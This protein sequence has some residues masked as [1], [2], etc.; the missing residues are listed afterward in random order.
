MDKCR[1]GYAVFCMEHKVTDSPFY[2]KLWQ[3]AWNARQPEVK[4]LDLGEVPRYEAEVVRGVD[5]QEV[6]FYGQKNGDWVEYSDLTDKLLP[7]VI[8][9]SREQMEDA[10]RHFIGP[11]RSIDIEYY[12][13]SLT[14]AA[15]PQTQWVPT[16]H[17]DGTTTIRPEVPIPTVEELAEVMYQDNTALLTNVQARYIAKVVHKL[18]TKGRGGEGV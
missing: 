4:M 11:F 2:W 10:L 15:Q 8:G 17:P 6:S 12:M 1:E 5:G 13:N 14:P 18:L 16:L 3:A 9:Y 7:P